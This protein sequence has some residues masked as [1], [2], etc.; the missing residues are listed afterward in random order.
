MA[1]LGI[2]LRLE[3]VSAIIAEALVAARVA[4]HRLLLVHAND[5][6]ARFEERVGSL[7]GVDVNTNLVFH[8][9]LS[10]VLRDQIHSPGIV[11]VKDPHGVGVPEMLQ[12]VSVEALALDD[13]GE[14]GTNE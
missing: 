7:L 3:V 13:V 12:V 8:L 10:L 5:A 14:E 4:G 11:V 9:L 6:Q 1:Q 2:S